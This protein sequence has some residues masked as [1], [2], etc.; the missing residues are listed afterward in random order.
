[1]KYTKFLPHLACLLSFAGAILERYEFSGVVAIIL[2][3]YIGFN[4]F[5]KK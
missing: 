2:V 5:N 4:Y 1:M 3:G